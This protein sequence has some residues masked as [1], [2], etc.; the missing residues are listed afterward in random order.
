MA[1][2][3]HNLELII[4]L[5]LTM[6]ILTIYQLTAERFIPMPPRIKSLDNK[7]K[8][9]NDYKR[10][11]SIYGSLVHAVI[12]V[13]FAGYI[14]FKQG[15]HFDYTPN[16]PINYVFVGFSLGYYIVDTIF[17]FVYKFGSF[18]NNIHHFLAV[19]VYSF[20]VYRGFGA[21]VFIFYMMVAEIPNPFMHIR[22]NLM[23]HNNVRK[24]LMLIGILFA[25]S[26]LLCRVYWIGITIGTLS[27]SVLP[28]VFKLALLTFWYLS[29]YWSYMVVDIFLKGLAEETK[30]GWAIFLHKM[31]SN[32]SRNPLKN[33]IMHSI[34]IILSYGRMFYYWSHEEV[35]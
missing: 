31:V 23:M 29:L 27:S 21:N 9:N 13:A 17:S 28:L 6:M 33:G 8:Q 34:F 19:G 3:L 12:N 7:I 24:Q 35:F 2:F 32:V 30:A 18:A 16:T 26:Y 4:P 20:I 1:E 14:S 11:L 5:T 15:V 25:I 22:K 10:Y